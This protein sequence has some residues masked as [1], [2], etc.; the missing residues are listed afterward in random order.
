M[1][2]RFRFIYIFY[3]S[4]YFC[5]HLFL[6]SFLPTSFL[7]FSHQIPVTCY[8]TA[9]SVPPFCHIPTTCNISLAHSFQLPC[10][11]YLLPL[12]DFLL[13]PSLPPILLFF[14]PFFFPW[15]FIWPGRLSIC[16]HKV[17][18]VIPFFL[19]VFYSIRYLTSNFIFVSWIYYIAI[20]TC[21]IEAINTHA[22]T[23]NF[24]MVPT[25][26][27]LSYHAVSIL[28]FKFNNNT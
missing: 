22:W 28:V 3:S 25:S 20:F 13:A 14:L 8:N 24:S 21:M 5:I 23:K 16:C 12:P 19:Q 17:F 9:T 4:I 26:P 27:Q 1:V 15:K 11:C 7:S 18:C 2:F 6:P 10:P